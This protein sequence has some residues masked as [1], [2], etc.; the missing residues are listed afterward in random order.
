MVFLLCAA[1]T[2]YNARAAKRKTYHVSDIQIGN[3][4]NYRHAYDKW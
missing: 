2:E 4:G 3:E 1:A